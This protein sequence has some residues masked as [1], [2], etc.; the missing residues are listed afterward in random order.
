VIRTCSG[1]YTL[2]DLS[3]QSFLFSTL[4]RTDTEMRMGISRCGYNKSLKITT[5]QES[6]EIARL[7]KLSAARKG[8]REVAKE[9]ISEYPIELTPKRK[10]DV[11]KTAVRD[12]KRREFTSLGIICY[13][14]RS[15]TSRTSGSYWKN[16][17]S[18]NTH[19][20]ELMFVP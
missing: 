8:L 13:E 6:T 4:S 19:S 18:V 17:I 11:M 9:H 7:L 15:T 10:V 16:E 2:F 20:S 12:C 3:P 5:C 1:V 14:S